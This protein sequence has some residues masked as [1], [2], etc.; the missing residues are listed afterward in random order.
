MTHRPVF[1]YDT[2]LRDGSQREGI[3]LSVADKLQVTSLLDELGVQLV[4]GGWPGSNPKDVA[5]FERVKELPLKTAKICAFSYTGRAHTHV[6]DD[7]NLLQLLAAGTEIVTIVG[8]SWILHVNEVL[9]VSREQNLVMIGNTVRFLRS[10]G[11]RVIYDAEHF[12]DGWRADREYAQETLCAACEA[13][14]ETVVLCDTNGGSLP[15]VVGEVT[16]AV[17][18]ATPAAV[19]IHTHND[20]ELAVA[21]ALSAVRAGATQVQGTINGYGER[22]GNCNLVS[23]IADLKL[24]MGIICVTDEQLG[25]LTEVARI[26]AEL[27]NLSPDTHQ[28]FVGVSAFA[29]KGGIHADATVKCPE[30]YQ[31]IRPELVG[32]R[33]RVLLSE[34][35]GKGN[36]L[37]KAQELGFSDN[38]GVDEARRVVEQIKLLEARGFS[39]EAAEASVALLFRRNR[40]QYRPPFE[41]IDF[42]SLVEHRDQRGLLAEA[43]VKV[44]VGGCTVHTAAEG[45]GP[46][47]ALDRALRKALLP[48][49]PVL[50]GI[51]LIDYKVR[52]LDGDKA[53]GA[54]TRVL[55]TSTS[56][57]DTW[58]T[59]GCSD[60]IIEA[61]WQAL[62]D[63]IETGLWRAGVETPV[64]PPGDPGA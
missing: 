61:S 24:K 35:S 12:F 33:T 47:E 58:T 56:G 34:L 7:P 5:Y 43:I 2:T 50:A 22:V 40:V 60:N 11:R 19:G 42:L 51:H 57:N 14:A 1:L 30:S 9:R 53:T 41:L 31:H 45:N 62:V 32:N 25:R 10:H 59:V 49:Y 28:P 38:L 3:S 44:K 63:S 8:K 17:V 46:V 6:E 16:A 26:V 55:I 64:V 36:L 27:C 54:T 15:W 37:F 39:F 52:I 29:H 13:G 4:E 48:Y 20:G 23:A 18:A 21:N